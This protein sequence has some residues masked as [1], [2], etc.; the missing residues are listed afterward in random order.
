MKWVKAKFGE[1]LLNIF[2]YFKKGMD[3]F[4]PTPSKYLKGKAE[5]M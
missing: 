3:F 1:I 2:G 4:I 5:L